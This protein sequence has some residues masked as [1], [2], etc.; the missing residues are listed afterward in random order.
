M[1]LATPT[2]DLAFA[3]AIA[4][5]TQNIFVCPPEGGA[6]S[7]WIKHGFSHSLRQQYI[8]PLFQS[9]LFTTTV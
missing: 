9:S 5:Y 1:Q 7:S 6:C 2:S 8:F 3:F 4:V